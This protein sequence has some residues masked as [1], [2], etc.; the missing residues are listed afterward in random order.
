MHLIHSMYLGLELIDMCID[1]SRPRDCIR[2]CG[3]V[4]IK[5]SFM[6]DVF[7]FTFVLFHEV[8]S[9]GKKH[10][11]VSYSPRRSDY[12]IYCLKLSLLLFFTV[13]NKLQIILPIRIVIIIDYLCIYS[14]T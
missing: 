7:Y 4:S 14:F 11:Y 3:V 12:L 2:F 6:A 8:V 13:Q 10:E 5:Q 9:N 1:S